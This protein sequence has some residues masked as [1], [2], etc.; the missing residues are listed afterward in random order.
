[1]AAG[2]AALPLFGWRAALAGA[3]AALGALFIN[4]LAEAGVATFYSIPRTRR[5]VEADV[6]ALLTS[7]L[8][9]R[10]DALHGRTD[11][12]LTATRAGLQND[13]AALFDGLPKPPTPEQATEA[14]EAFALRMEAAVANGISGVKSSAMAA[15]S[16]KGVAA[17]RNSADAESAFKMAVGAHPK[18][19]A[20]AILGLAALK[21]ADP[22]FYKDVVGVAIEAFTYAPDSLDSFLEKH[23]DKLRIPGFGGRDEKAKPRHGLTVVG[24]GIG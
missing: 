23:G 3:L 21:R 10:L 18:G 19:G 2:A 8:Q 15:L 4:V 22:A 9:P 16:E 5:L 20:K 14:Q 1:M 6:R 24:S 17:R 13:L 7:E 11:A 12:A